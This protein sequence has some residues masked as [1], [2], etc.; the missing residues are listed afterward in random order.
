MAVENSVVVASFCVLKVCYQIGMHVTC[1]LVTY[2]QWNLNENRL[3]NCCRWTHCFVCVWL[4]MCECCEGWYISVFICRIVD[5]DIFC[6][7][8]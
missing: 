5:I 3:I 4:C 7:Q 2:L 1:L 8:F 6:I